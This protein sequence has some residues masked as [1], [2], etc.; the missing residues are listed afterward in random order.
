MSYPSLLDEPFDL[1][2]YPLETV[3]AE[4]IVT[5][6][7]RG[8]ATTRDRDFADVYILTGRH[9]IDAGQLASAIRATGAHRSSD[10]R[11]L[12]SVLVDLA[13]VRLADWMRFLARAGLDESAPASFAET[14]RAISDFA[15]PILTGEVAS[16]VW[17]P[18]ARL[19]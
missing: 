15:D 12:R 1:I 10:L 19:A 11:P 18:A 8:D 5:M 3:L 9:E 7:D 16:G 2:G 17:D 4:K 6:I 14:I 13:Q